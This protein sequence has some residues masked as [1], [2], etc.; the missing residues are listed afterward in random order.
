M[1]R[2]TVRI[3]V[4]PLLAILLLA[5][6]GCGGSEDDPKPVCGSLGVDSAAPATLSATGLYSDIASKTIDAR[7]KPFQPRFEL[8]SDGADKKRWA[9]IPECE[10]IDTSDMEEWSV[11][12]GTRLFKEFSVDGVPIETRLVERIGDGP[13]DYLYAAYQWEADGSD[14]LHVPKGVQDAAGTEH[15][16]P[17]EN[18]CTKC[19]DRFPARVL[20]FGAVQLG[21]EQAGL[22]VASL[23][24]DG[25]LSDPPV[26]NNYQ[27]PGGAPVEAALGYLHGNCSSCHNSTSSGISSPPLDFLLKTSQSAT[28]DLGA[29]EMIGA[30]AIHFKGPDVL[31]TPGDHEASALWYRMSVRDA[32]Q[33]PPL[34]TDEVDQT[35]LKAIETWI[36]SLTP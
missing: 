5:V 29:Y 7:V 17:S 20:G 27:V 12:V 34:A 11:P 32:S 25:Q 28:E 14:A 9:Y 24:A 35:G 8:W 33:M 23:S 31:V 15:D 18:A 2:L 13:D 16:I 10:T 1:A 26:E 6:V 21:H 4:E 30:S 3:I 36:N 19:H 22:T